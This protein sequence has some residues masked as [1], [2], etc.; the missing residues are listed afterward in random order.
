MK[1]IFRTLGISLF[2][3]AC[4][5]FA[6]SF[7]KI[8]TISDTVSNNTSTTKPSSV[9]STSSPQ[10]VTQTTQAPVE[11]TQTT[12]T[13]TTRT[14]TTTTSQQSSSEKVSFTVNS[15]DTS[16]SVAEKLFEQGIIKNID[17]FNNYMLNNNLSQYIQTGT[18]ELHSNMSLE[19]LGQTLTTYPGN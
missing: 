17:E 1:N 6:L 5:L 9:V 14:Q 8:I 7:F 12:T 16:Y 13:Q 15:D 3:T 10:Q 19:E 11:T 4:L 2:L 18:F